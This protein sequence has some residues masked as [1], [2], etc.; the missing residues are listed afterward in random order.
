VEDDSTYLTVVHPYPPN[1]NLLLPADQRALALWL[2]C[3]AGKQEVLLTMFHKPKVGLV[4]LTRFLS[5][6]LLD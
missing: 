6:F 1:A 3:C 4:A 2:A 5:S